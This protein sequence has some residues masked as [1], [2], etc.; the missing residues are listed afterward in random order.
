VNV[1]LGIDLG[2]VSTNVVVMNEQREILYNLYLRTQGQPIPTVQKG[3]AM[4]LA[5]LGSKL[6]VRGVG[7]TGSGRH[8]AGVLI[9]ADSVKYEITAHAVAAS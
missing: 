9:G 2:S 7:T 1:F 8:L 5:E 4:L 6:K 3:I